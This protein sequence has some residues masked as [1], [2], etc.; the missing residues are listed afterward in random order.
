M[1][2]FDRV[3]MQEGLAQKLDF[4]NIQLDG[5]MAIPWM[6][7]STAI[8]DRSGNIVAVATDN[9]FNGTTFTDT[10]MDIIGYTTPNQLGGE[11]I[12]NGSTDYAGF[13][14]DNVLDGHTLFNQ[15]MN[16][17]SISF[18]T[19]VGEAVFSNDME[20]LGISSEHGNVFDPVEENLESISDSFA[21]FN[22]HTTNN[23]PDFDGSLEAIDGLVNIGDLDVSTLDGLDF[24]DWI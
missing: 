22:T 5:T 20:L 9:A 23:F 8:I 15:D 16:I 12:F 3:Y 14:V 17:E 2:L 21:N 13:T 11:N 1:S 18:D 10:G 24:L 7:D 19:P 4:L 6:I